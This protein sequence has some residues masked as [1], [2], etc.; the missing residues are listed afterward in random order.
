MGIPGVPGG[1]ASLPAIDCVSHEYQP[2]KQH[3][4]DVNAVF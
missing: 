4:L 1:V 2:P 3:F